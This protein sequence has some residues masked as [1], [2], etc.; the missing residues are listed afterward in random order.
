MKG[1]AYIKTL[2]ILDNESFVN[3]ERLSHD[4]LNLF[5]LDNNDENFNPN[6]HNKPSVSEKIFINDKSNIG[7]VVVNNNNSK[8]TENRDMHFLRII[9]L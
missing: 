9:F 4:V 7:I 6:S 2:I 1:R 5:I 8:G 3:H